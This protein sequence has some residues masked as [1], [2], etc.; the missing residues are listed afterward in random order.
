MTVDEQV[1]AFLEYFNHDIPDP[2][3]EPRRFEYYLKLWRY[4]LS[5]V[6]HGQQNNVA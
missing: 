2:D 3:Q 5:R 6:Q 1:Q 4:H